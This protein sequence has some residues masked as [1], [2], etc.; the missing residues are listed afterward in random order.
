MAY[1][2]ILPKLGQTVEESTIVEWMK[3][4][5]DEVARGDVLFS[6][7][8]DKATLDVEATRKGFLRKIMVPA[9]VEVPVLTVVAYITRT[10]DEPLEVGESGSGGVGE[11]G[12]EG[13]VDRGNFGCCWDG[14]L[15]NSD[16]PRH[17]NPYLC[18]ATGAEGGERERRRS[19]GARR[20]WAERAHR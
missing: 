6:V 7:E 12:S 10:A 14:F 5:G 9:G 18:F 20:Q 11:K 16:T 17:P 15:P 8:T 1:E 2:V 19:R 13:V 4:E 3:E